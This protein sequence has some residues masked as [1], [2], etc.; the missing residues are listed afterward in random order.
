MS[1]YAQE[2]RH[3][4]TPVSSRALHY[5]Y[6]AGNMRDQLAAGSTGEMVAIRDYCLGK[7]RGRGQVH[8]GFSHDRADLR[9]WFNHKYNRFTV[10]FFLRCQI[11]FAEVR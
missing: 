9:L 7:F 4:F 11:Y 1:A 3:H 10:L 6:E 5:P 2:C 8:R